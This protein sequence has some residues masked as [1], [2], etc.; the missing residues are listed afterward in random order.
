MRGEAAGQGGRGFKVRCSAGGITVSK[1]QT[2]QKPAARQSVR[3][4]DIPTRSTA[5]TPQA[6]RTAALQVHIVC[7]YMCRHPAA[8]RLIS[9]LL[10]DVPL[11]RA[12]IEG[13]VLPAYPPSAPTTQA[14][15]A[16]ANT[17]RAI[18]TSSKGSEHDHS[19]S[20]DEGGWPISTAASLHRSRPRFHLVL[21]AYTG[22]HH[23]P[24]EQHHQH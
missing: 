17:A 7:M 19:W 5:M 1:V 15:T 13:A 10:P 23:T 8:A 11:R 22:T 14:T 4:G 12:H 2:E 20:L 16:A 6:M 21:L 24:S 9:P 3:K 18:R